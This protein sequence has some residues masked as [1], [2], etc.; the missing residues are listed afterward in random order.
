VAGKLLWNTSLN[1]QKIQDD[2]Y[3]KGCGKAAKLIQSFNKKMEGAWKAAT[4][5]GKDVTAG[6]LA[7]TRI[8]E[9]FTPALLNDCAED[10]KKA[11]AIAE[12]DLVKKRVAFIQNGLQY[13]LLTVNATQKAKDLL[14]MGVPL[15]TKDNSKQEVELST[16]TTPEAKKIKQDQHKLILEALKAWEERDAFVEAHKNDHVFSYFWIKYNDKNRY[17]NPHQNLKALADAIN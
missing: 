14:A 4:K 5:D 12:N 3:E 6:T 15:F 17:F 13:T 7:D 9:L 16:G 11:A 1:E 2:Y 10:L 8:L